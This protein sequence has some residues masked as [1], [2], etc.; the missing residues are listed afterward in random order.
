MADISRRMNGAYNDAANLLSEAEGDSFMG[1]PV[2]TQSSPALS[3][4]LVVYESA[5]GVFTAADAAAEATFAN[6]LSIVADSLG[7]NQFVLWRVGPSRTLEWTAHGIGTPTFGEAIYLQDGGGL[8]TSPGSWSVK[9]GYVRD[10]N[11][12]QIEMG[13]LA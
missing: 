8:G 1:A 7:S 9:V 12:I 6:G 2:V 5:D 13:L 10:A 11:N 3:L 4:G